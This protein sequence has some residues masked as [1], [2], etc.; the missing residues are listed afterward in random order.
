MAADSA[1]S[2]GQRF[3]HDLRRIRE[4]RGVS[5]RAVHEESKIPLN[6]LEQ[7]EQTGLFDHP[8]FNRVYLRSLVRT[9]ADMV[10]M[11]AQRALDALDEALAGTYAGGLDF[12][13]ED[14][15]EEPQASRRDET[16]A[17]P[18]SE[19]P[20]SEPGAQEGAAGAAAAASATSKE[21]D[22]EPTKSQAA[23]PMREASSATAS[24]PA[25]ER[26]AD[27]EPR[28]KAEPKR[29]EEEAP[30]GA[31]GGA[32][33]G[34]AAGAAGGRGRAERSPRPARKSS[35]EP[36]EIGG[37]NP[38]WIIGVVALLVLAGAGWFV[39]NALTGRED[40]RVAEQ[41]QTPTP[42]DTTSTPEPE[43]PEPTPAATIGDSLDVVV[44]A[45]NGPVRSILVRRDDDL[46]RP[47]WI[48]EGRAKSFPAADSVFI[49]EQLGQIRLLVEGFEYPVPSQGAIALRRGTV[50]AFLDTLRAQRASL[51][52]Q[53]E[54]VPVG[55]IQSQ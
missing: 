26:A 54:R 46:R 53:P 19:P 35:G 39:V 8:M 34:A 23:P 2:A 24:P 32:A 5:L 42:T 14:V 38:R 16:A 9:Y 50:Q 21:P 52:V 7:F 45:A 13:D 49:Q 51:D 27:A 18:P 41:A 6:L 40:A 3:A 36:I 28:E 22:A 20:S 43:E 31:A 15:A 48:E 44:V 1:G 4:E 30:S 29:P 33:A 17:P 12:A 10:E 11:P 25:Q 47:Y 55:P 37:V